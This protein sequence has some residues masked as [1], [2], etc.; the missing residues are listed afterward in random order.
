MDN[1]R[2]VLAREPVARELLSIH[3]PEVEDSPPFLPSHL[4]SALLGTP[5]T[6]PFLCSS[7]EPW[8]QRVQFQ[9]VPRQNV[10][11]TLPLGK[12][13]APLGTHRAIGWR[14]RAWRQAS[15]TGPQDLSSPKTASDLLN[16]HPYCRKI[17]KTG[18]SG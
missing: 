13:S 4:L 8:A 5:L 10:D 14:P 2:L 9:V 16:W 12:H 17:G 1:T 7:D 11:E 3:K 6:G 15:T 18:K